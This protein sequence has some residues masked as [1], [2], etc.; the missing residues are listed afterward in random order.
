MAIWEEESRGELHESGSEW[1][2]S[3]GVRSLISFK[4]TLDVCGHG[5]KERPVGCFYL[6]IFSS[7]SQL[8]ELAGAN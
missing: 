8:S 6:F 2:G 4:G 1:T 7:H 3:Y 5:F